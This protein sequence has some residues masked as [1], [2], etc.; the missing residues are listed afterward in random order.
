MT[1][2]EIEKRIDQIKTVDDMGK[3]YFDM[4]EE[5]PNVTSGTWGAYPEDEVWNAIMEREPIKADPLLKDE[6][7]VF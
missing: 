7:V 6:G 1:D 4:F 3:L 2:K 5:Y